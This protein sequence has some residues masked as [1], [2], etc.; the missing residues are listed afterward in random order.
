M[1]FAVVVGVLLASGS[2]VQEVCARRDRHRFPPPGTVINGLHVR[3]I[4]SGGPAVVF[5][6]RMAASCVPWSVVQSHLAD[7]ARTYSYDRPGGCVERSL[8]RRLFAAQVH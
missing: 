5:E 1:V 4:E 6:A 8:H 3:Q 2:L 7:S